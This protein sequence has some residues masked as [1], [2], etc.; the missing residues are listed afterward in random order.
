LIHLVKDT[1]WYDIGVTNHGRTIAEIVGCADPI[2]Y[3][4]ENSGKLPV[5]FPT[6]T[7]IR[8]IVPP[9][10]V[11][12]DKKIDVTQIQ[13]DDVLNFCGSHEQ[14]SRLFK[15]EISIYAV[16]II[17]FRDLLTPPTNKPHELHW[18]CRVK[19]DGNQLTIYLDGPKECNYQT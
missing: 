12:P 5:S 13:E 19:H 11:L 16:G 17:K 6:S 4:V 14:Q 3:L 1:Q 10:R 7:T 2:L 9:V 8:E 18:C 15:G